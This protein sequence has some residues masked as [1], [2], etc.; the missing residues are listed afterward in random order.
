VPVAVTLGTVHVAVTAVKVPPV[1][2]Y[3]DQLRDVD[4]TVVGGEPALPPGGTFV[5]GCVSLAIFHAP[6]TNT[7]E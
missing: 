4:P 3:P 5:F 1:A 6:L 7:R 2:T